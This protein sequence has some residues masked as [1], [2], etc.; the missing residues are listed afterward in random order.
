VTKFGFRTKDLLMLELMEKYMKDDD[1]EKIVA[2]KL[3]CSPITLRTR[4]LRIRNRY[5]D[6]VNYIEAYKSWRQKLFRLSGG[7]FRGL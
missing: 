2:R 1:W 4:L 5:T 7:R 3:K 6:A